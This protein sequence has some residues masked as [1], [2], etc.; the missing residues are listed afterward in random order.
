MYKVMQDKASK[1]WYA[2]KKEMLG[3]GKLS[4]VIIS[5]HTTR[6]DALDAIEEEGI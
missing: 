5:T 6:A 3:I 4:W 1:E 2:C